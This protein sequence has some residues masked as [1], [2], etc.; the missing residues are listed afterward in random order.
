MPKLDFIAYNDEATSVE[1]AMWNNKYV[2]KPAIHNINLYKKPSGST[3]NGVYGTVEVVDNNFI[4]NSKRDFFPTGYTYKDSNGNSY[5]RDNLFKKR[6]TSSMDIYPSANLPMEVIEPGSSGVINPNLFP[7]YLSLKSTQVANLDFEVGS[8]S[9]VYGYTIQ[10]VENYGYYTET[11]DDRYN[12]KAGAWVNDISRYELTGISRKF[13]FTYYNNSN[14]R[15]TILIKFNFPVPEDSQG[16]AEVD[17]NNAFIG[18]IDNDGKYTGKIYQY[19]RIESSEDNQHAFYV[20]PY[21]DYNFT[22]VSNTYYIPSKNAAGKSILT[23]VKS[24]Q[25]Y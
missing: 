21:E 11:G 22:I 20:E 23:Y 18:V 15:K 25:V 3:G 1:S 8:Y 5:S 17:K 4:T 16:A 14:S 9:S 13:N 19:K 7:S 2:Y 12:T 24:I 10:N 6:F